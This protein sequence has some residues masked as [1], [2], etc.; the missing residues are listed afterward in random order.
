MRRILIGFFAVLFL[1]SFAAA[2]PTPDCSATAGGTAIAIPGPGTDFLEVG[3]DKHDYFDNSVA[4]TNA[5]LCAFVLRDTLP[6]LTKPA[7]GLDRYMLVEVSREGQSQ[8]VSPADFDDTV[9]SV[10]QQLGDASRM[11]RTF[12]E[13]E[14]QARQKLRKMNASDDISFGKPVV[15]GTLFQIKDAYAVGMIV[16]VTS[17][18]VT[19]RV[20]NASVLMRVRNRLLFVYLYADY[21]D[22]ATYKWVGDTAEGWVRHILAANNQ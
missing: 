11:N 12:R 1:C 5:L 3:A 18:G 8:D 7:G 20:L 17:H 16:P 4:S 9:T 10:K 2:A 21:K 6:R 19:S 22:E 15:L 14:E 13:T